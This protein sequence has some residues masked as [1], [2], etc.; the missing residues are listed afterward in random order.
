MIISGTQF[1]NPVPPGRTP[2]LQ[3]PLPPAPQPAKDGTDMCPD[4]AHSLVTQ[5][6]VWTWTTDTPDG[7]AT[8][9]LLL[10]GKDS[11]GSAAQCCVND[12]GKMYALLGDSLWHQWDGKSWGSSPV[13][14]PSVIPAPCTY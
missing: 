2:W 1:P 5:Y 10:D 13:K 8:W 4:P 9:P 7:G 6:G 14:N 11:G 3:P 12:G